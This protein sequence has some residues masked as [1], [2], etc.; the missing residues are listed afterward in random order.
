VLKFLLEDDQVKGALDSL[1]IR[2]LPWFREKTVG[3]G[4]SFNKLLTTVQDGDT[5]L[6]MDGSRRVSFRPLIDFERYMY[7]SE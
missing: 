3:M 6:D 7:L 2:E 5:I 1:E 4:F